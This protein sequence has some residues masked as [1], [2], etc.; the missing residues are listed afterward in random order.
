MGALRLALKNTGPALRDFAGPS[1]PILM[2]ARWVGPYD[3]EM[4]G[5]H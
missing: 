5:R 2:M 1:M 4:G 3:G